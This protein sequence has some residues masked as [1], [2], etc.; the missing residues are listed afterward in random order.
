MFYQKNPLITIKLFNALVKPI[1]L[2]A[3]DFWGVLNLP[4]NNPVENLHLSFCKQ[5]L[6][7]QKQTTN[8]GVL[9]E[10]GI[11][12]SIYAKQIGFKNWGKDI[13]SK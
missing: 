11:P 12:L 4:H 9:I 10:L 13:K 8:V 3:S 1:L 7:V 2:Y 6:G 5:L